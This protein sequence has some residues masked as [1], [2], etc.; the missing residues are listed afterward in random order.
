MKMTTSFFFENK[1]LEVWVII[2][3]AKLPGQMQL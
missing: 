1:S 2:I 3:A